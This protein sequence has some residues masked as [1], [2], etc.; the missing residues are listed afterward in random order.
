MFSEE[1]NKSLKQ[2]NY[3]VAALGA[4]THLAMQKKSQSNTSAKHTAIPGSS[5]HGEDNY[6]NAQVSNFN[7]SPNPNKEC[8]GSNRQTFKTFR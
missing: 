7:L 5:Q 4:V 3:G 1:D 6:E 2:S 8:I